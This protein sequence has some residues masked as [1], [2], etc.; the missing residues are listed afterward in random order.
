MTNWT[1]RFELKIPSTKNYYHYE[2]LY[3][4]VDGSKISTGSKISNDPINVMAM[5]MGLPK[6]EFNVIYPKHD[7]KVKKLGILKTIAD[8]PET[9]K[10]HDHFFVPEGDNGEYVQ[11][12]LG[13]SSIGGKSVVCI[14]KPIVL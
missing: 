5:F 10:Y 4:P 9:L 3:I 14:V 1:H 8:T 13:P 6:D 12:T 11:D 7:F 2:Y